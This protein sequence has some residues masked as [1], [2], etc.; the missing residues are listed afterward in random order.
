MRRVRYLSYDGLHWGDVD[1]GMIKR[2]SGVVGH[3]DGSEMPLSEVSLLPPCEPGIIVCVGRNY[4]EHI[5][6]LGNMPQGGDLP[7]EPGLFLK[8][9]NTLSGAGDDIPYPS[10]TQDLQF[11][12]ELAVVIGST[13]R[14]VTPDMALDHVLGYTCAVDVTARD[15]QRADLQWVRGKSADAFCPVGPWLETDLDPADLSVR[16]VVNGEVKQDGRT[17]DMIFPV[18]DVL[19]YISRFMT[20][21]AGDLVLTGTPD[22]VG[23]L[24]VGDHIEVTVEGI[25][26]LINQVEHERDARVAMFDD[27]E[28]L[29]ARLDAREQ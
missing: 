27:R 19:A 21:R 24:Q 14:D 13:M 26:T 15:K 18:A 29:T 17:S 11:E 28:G 7:K 2:L 5:R 1:G 20:L 6:E 8:G 25:G 16:T 22:G 3:P 23:K 4:A 12:G 10:W 9:V